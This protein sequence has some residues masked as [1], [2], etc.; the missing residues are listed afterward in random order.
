MPQRT[1]PT[2]TYIPRRR[3][4][5]ANLHGLLNASGHL[6]QARQVLLQG[7]VC[8]LGKDALLSVAHADGV[9]RLRPI[10]H[11]Q[12]ALDFELALLSY[13]HELRLGG[14]RCVADVL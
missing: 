3:S 11:H 6:L 8:V 2:S 14:K 4:G 5:V 10:P 9:G 1:T 13:G 7:H 12:L